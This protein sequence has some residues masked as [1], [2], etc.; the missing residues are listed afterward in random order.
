MPSSLSPEITPSPLVID[1]RLRQGL[2]DAVIAQTG[3]RNAAL[4]AYLREALAG[5]D[6]EHGA[7]LSEP[8]FEGAAGYRSSGRTPLSLANDLLHPDMA[9]ALSA[10]APGDDYRFNYPAY[11]HQLEAWKLL[12]A[13]QRNSVLVSSGT[14]SGKTECFLVPLLNDLAVESE[15]VGRLSG[16][17]ALML[18]PLNAL[19]ASQEERLR[20]WTRPFEGRV[21]FGLY[22]GLMPDKRKSDRDRDRAETPEQVLDRSTLRADPPPILVTNNTMLEYMTIRR[23][24]RPLVERSRGMLRWI[25]IDEAHSYVGSA[26]AEIS[27]LLRR[28]LQ[29][30]QVKASDVRF[31]ATSATIGGSDEGARRDLQRYLADLAGVPLDRVHVVFGEREAVTLPQPGPAE[32]LADTDGSREALE[33]NPAVQA[34]V[35]QAE[36]GA[37]SLSQAAVHARAAGTGAEQLLERIAA[38]GEDGRRPLLPMRVHEFVRAVPGLWSCFDP[39]CSGGKP[40]DWPFGAVLFERAEVCPH[41]AAAVFE[42]L[43]CSECGEPWLDVYDDGD[44]LAPTRTKPD[45]DE[46]AAAGA[47]STGAFEADDEEEEAPPAEPTAPRIGRRRLLGV[48][49]FAGCKE[50]AVDSKTGAL[51]ER[52]SSG[53]MVWASNELIDDACPSCGVGPTAETQSPLRPFRYGAPFL[54]QNAAP[55]LLEGVSTHLSNEKLV[56]GEGRQLLSFT[57][58]RQGTARFAA[59]IETQSER[60]FV[61]AFIYHL[62]Q[63]A[64]ARQSDAEQRATLERKIAKFALH[65]EDPDFAEMLDQARAELAALDQP[66]PVTWKAAVQALADDPTVKQWIRQVWHDRDERYRTSPEAFAEFLMLR[67]LAR[68]PRRANAVETMGLAR[69]SFAPLE[70]LSEAAVPSEF[71]DKGLGAQDWRDFLYFLIDA[72]IRNLFILRMDRR[73]ARWLLP[74]RAFLRNVVGPNEPLGNPSDKAWPKARSGAVKSNAVKLLERVLKLDA[75]EPED[76]ATLNDILERA[77]RAVRPLLENSANTYALDFSRASL[78]PVRD[79]WLCPVTNRVLPRLALGLS[80]YALR[81]RLPAAERRPDPISLPTLPITFPRTAQDRHHIADY[82]VN[83]AVTADLRD[84]GV[85]SDLHTRAAT[86]APYIRAE[87]HS[88]QQPPSRLRGFE[89]EFKRHEINLLAC[90]TTMEMGVDIGSVEAVLNTNVPP[91]IANYRQR[92]GRAGRRGQSF[93]TSLTLARNTPLDRE[94]F[95]RP[96]DYLKRELRAPL[97]KLDSNRI[98]QRHVNAL[99]LA[100]WFAEADGQLAKTKTGDF[101]GCPGDLSGAASADAPV[102]LF[103]RWLADPTTEQQ[104]RVSIDA[105]VSGTILERRRDLLEVTR[106]AFVEA[107]DAFSK[108]WASVRDQARDVSPEAVSS[109]EKRVR[110][111]CGEPLLKELAN[112]SLLPGHGF[113]TSVVPFINDCAETRDRDRAQGSQAGDDDR[114]NNNRYDYPSRNADVAIREYAPGAEVVIDGLVW[115]SAGVTLNWQR[116]ATDLDAKEVQSL[117]CFWRCETCKAAGAGHSAP[118]SCVECGATGLVIRRFLEPSGFRVAWSDKPHAHTDMAQFIEPETPAVSAGDVAWAPLLDAALGR[119]RASQDGRVFHLSH[120]PSKAGYRVCLE[121]GRAASEAGETLADHDA[122][123]PRKGASGRCS[124]NDRAFSITEPI[125]LGHEVLTDVA[126]LQPSGLSSP[127]AA[128][129]LASAMRESL[130]RELGIETR[131]LGLS[132]EARSGILGD[133]THSVFLFD[134][135]TGGAGYAPQLFS[136][137]PALLEAVVRRLDCPAECERGCSSCVLAI[138]L[139]A[140]QEIVD[141]KA[142]LEFVNR[143]R[144][145][146]AQPRD[147]DMAGIDA[148]LS[149]PAADAIVRRLK[150]DQILTL[151]V[152]EDLDVSALY[153]PPLSS[154]FERAHRLGAAVRLALPPTAFEAMD[155]AARRGLRNASHRFCFAPVT[156]DPPPARNG[157]CLVAHIE[158][159]D[160]GVAYY[161]RDPNSR[162]AGDGW[163]VGIEHP[164]VTVRSKPPAVVAVAEEQLERT[165]VAGDRVRELKAPLS[166][167]AHQFGVGMVNTLLKPELEAAGLWK[168]GRLVSIEYTDRYLVAPL[169]VLL[170]TR[171]LAA[172]RDALAPGLSPEITVITAPLKRDDFRGSPTQ[173][174]QNWLDEN[175]REQTILALL[176]AVRLNARYIGR[177]AAHNRRLTLGYD[178]GSKAVIFFDQGFGYWRAPSGSRHDFNRNPAY[179]AKALTDFQ[180][181]ISGQGDSFIAVTRH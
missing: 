59:N 17:R 177:G 93:S 101:F 21:R 26:A 181:F 67:E 18:Y 113:P 133:R 96:V 39:A 97:V 169:P 170:L 5:R 43:N 109:L 158:D 100:R 41:C 53:T 14:G 130:S 105:L 66:Q 31:V 40:A 124:G 12:T 151:M 24:D 85:W 16:V 4:N 131:E 98:V 38:K 57:D 46:F 103:G 137:I 75:S 153:R 8:V 154:L 120:G 126:E 50:V 45:G 47:M 42:I 166:R 76:R 35:R 7:L 165:A 142:A 172:L 54:L 78:E 48:R 3:S 84:R 141:R 150:T 64:L 179:Q 144:G 140:E 65:A 123:T 22:N 69:L 176:G 94:A 174:N 104:A 87:E 91:S 86:F 36:A 171:T 114:R 25:I 132:V 122:L 160:G 92:V 73:D 44:H 102:T 125:A 37:I 106:T 117:R 88:A 72:S 134:Q 163:G 147:E 58:S 119:Y 62:T 148:K 15:R 19:I 32:A 116:P 27:L 175:D 145:E 10:G 136:D 89:D 30:F 51:L 71:R 60:G 111:M 108:S 168:P 81:S 49:P 156:S 149:A 99:L 152:S 128:W 61:R 167:A 146:L 159:A 63:K 115:T 135:S 121:C 112:R 29:T 79:A 110:R 143:L 13:D 11:S 1:G 20:Q 83:D 139:F 180:G 178:D 9:A 2:T 164:V 107:H 23:Q 52:R 155:D 33:R 129:A 28:V 55:T 90:S 80:P 68:R 95:R 70:A 56:P 162:T 6:I 82:L 34:L 118:D 74:K 157:A 138:D 127:G 173:I 161:S 77:W